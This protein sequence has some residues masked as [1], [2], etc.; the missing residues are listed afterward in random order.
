MC[1][2]DRYE[3]MHGFENDDVSLGQG[4]HVKRHDIET[5]KVVVFIGQQ[6]SKL[7]LFL[8]IDPLL[9][10]IEKIYTLGQDYQL[11]LVTN[12]S[13]TLLKKRFSLIL[14]A[15][16]AK[17][18]GIIITNPQLGRCQDIVKAVQRIITQRE[19]KYYTLVIRT[20]MLHL[21]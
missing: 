11:G 2:R 20:F 6:T 12:E 18:F 4:L 3:A 5:A 7:L 17:T 15:Q 9:K 13:D 21:F 19:L 14:K 8:S 16:N 10:S 1:I